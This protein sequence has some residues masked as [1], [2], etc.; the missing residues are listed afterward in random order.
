MS[1]NYVIHCSCG[2]NQTIEPQGLRYETIEAAIKLMPAF[3]KMRDAEWDMSE[4]RG[5]CFEHASQLVGVML[6]HWRHGQLSYSYDNNS[7]PP[8]V[9]VPPAE[10]GLPVPCG[11]CQGRRLVACPSCDGVADHENDAYLLKVH[12]LALEALY[13]SVQPHLEAH[14]DP[15]VMKAL[16]HARWLLTRGEQA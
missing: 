4:L 1:G 6:E 15:K 5:V 10:V 8:V 14:A 2:V 13:K 11:T 3:E 12:R 9:L 16:D 7:N